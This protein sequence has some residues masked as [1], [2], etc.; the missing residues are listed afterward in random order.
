[1]MDDINFIILSRLKY[2]SILFDVIKGPSDNPGGKG[3]P[4][5]VNSAVTI[6]P[7]EPCPCGS[8]KNT[9]NV[10]VVKFAAITELNGVVKT[11]D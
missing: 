3:N 6:A 8:G 11:P 5:K 10:T 2:A 1:M 9:A 4:H 7:D